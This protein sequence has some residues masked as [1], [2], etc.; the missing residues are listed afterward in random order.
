[1]FHWKHGNE[2]ALRFELLRNLKPYSL[3]LP[4]RSLSAKS[5]ETLGSQ[6][7]YGG[8]AHTGDGKRSSQAFS[9]GLR[10]QST[11]SQKVSTLPKILSSNDKELE[12]DLA[13]NSQ[14][15]TDRVEYVDRIAHF[16]P[17]FLDSNRKS[18]TRRQQKKIVRWQPPSVTRYLGNFNPLGDWTT[19]LEILKHFYQAPQNQQETDQNVGFLRQVLPSDRKGGIT[20][21]I[22]PP[23]RPGTW[24]P[25]SL[26]GYIKDLISFQPPRPILYEVLPEDAKRQN[27]ASVSGTA[28]EMERLLHDPYARQSIT[29]DACNAA[30][31][32][33]YD[34]EMMDRARRVFSRME[35]LNLDPTTNTWNIILRACASHKDVHSF[36]F[37]LNQML[38][39]DCSPNPET[40]VVFVM[41]QSNEENKRHIVGEMKSL[42]VM[43]YPGIRGDVAAQMVQHEYVKHMRS[44]RRN[45]RPF[46]D[47]MQEEYGQDWLSTS[48][49]NIIISEILKSKSPK[50][51]SVV[52]VL[53]FLYEMKQ[54]SFAANKT[55][56]D[57]LLKSCEHVGRQDLVIEVL[58]IFEEH[59]ALK[60][61][62]HAHWRLFQFAWRR[63][64]LNLLRTVWISACL[65]GFVTFEMQDLI[66]HSLLADEEAKSSHQPKTFFSLAGWF[67]LSVDPRKPLPGSAEMRIGP[68]VTRRPAEIGLLAVKSNLATA[69]EARLT[70]GLV[71]TLRQAL[72]I[73]S[74]WARHGFWQAWE[75]QEALLSDKYQIDLT[76]RHDFQPL[77][78]SSGI[79]IR[80][81]VSSRRRRRLKQIVDLRH[82]THAKS[83][84]GMKIGS[85]ARMA[86][87]NPSTLRFRFKP[88][89][90]RR[91]RSTKELPSQQVRKRTTS[92]SQDLPELYRTMRAVDHYARKA[93]PLRRTIWKRRGN[94][95]Q[96]G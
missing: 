94:S 24:S 41:L 80:K 71:V 65:N 89:P 84:T 96:H 76:I 27:L 13:S 48:A 32:Y 77:K 36:T 28:N 33:F 60:P 70:N 12:N 22:R 59:W 8:L 95:S 29:V 9:S 79:K 2:H 64:R 54:R 91:R 11:I 86:M 87:R 31:Q 46:L 42:G 19:G 51:V 20:K 67:V 49:G 5:W 53:R 10:G 1:M 25:D 68:E 23:T 16:L 92:F 44:S 72:E 61:G 73:D 40:W 3:P 35:H 56:M 83:L 52:H 88:Q 55:T 50:I 17:T 37:L 47:K 38:R 57:M 4:L 7:R 14:R 75:K 26:T 15:P 90:Q 45:R 58:D 62:R 43:D 82:K 81:Q 66:F 6:Q 21:T 78:K 30:L 74:H 93:R 39:R 69:G 85:I 63:K 18:T 34:R